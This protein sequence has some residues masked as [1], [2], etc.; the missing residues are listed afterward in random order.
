M[1]TDSKAHADAGK[2]RDTITR[3]DPELAGAVERPHVAGLAGTLLSLQRSHGNRFVH[4]L[5]SGTLIQ[6]KCSCGGT[7][8]QCREDH[9]EEEVIQRK[10]A[11]AS[12]PPVSQVPRFSLAPEEDASRASGVETARER[13]RVTN[14]NDESEM[15]ADRIAEQLMRVSDD[16]LRPA[17]SSPMFS[18]IHRAPRSTA[19]A[20][21]VKGGDIGLRLEGEIARA[22]S[23]G[24]PLGEATRS[25]FEARLGTDFRDVRIHSGAEAAAV[26]EKLAA[27]AFTMGH[28]IFFNRG[29]YQPES[30]EGMKLL[31]HELVHVVQQGDR[32]A[33]QR[34]LQRSKI[35]YR[36]LTWSDFKATPDMGSTWAAVT[37][38]GFPVPGWTPTRDAVDTKKE[39]TVDKAKSTEFTATVKVDPSVYDG[40]VALM[41]QEESWVKP[42]HK[43]DGKTW[44]NGQAT[45]CEKDFD[46]LAAQAKKD[47]K[48]EAD[49]CAQA[50]KHGNTSYTLTVGGTKI[51]ASD[52]SECA[53][54]LQPACE[55]AE[56]KAASAHQLP[57]SDG[58]NFASAKT[59]ADCK[60]D[61]VEK[62]KV[63]EAAESARILKH[64]QGHFD[65]SKVMADKARASLKAKAATFTA[66]ETRCGKVAALNAAIRSFNAFNASTV[67]GKLGSDWQDSKEKAESDYDDQTNHGMK[68]PE[69]AAWEAKITGGLNEYDPTKPPPTTTPATPGPA[70]QQTTPGSPATAPTQ[71]PPPKTP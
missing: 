5:A 21:T 19:A 29:R 15:E 54:K 45:D 55:A 63:H 70:T 59:K 26:S 8:E 28:D 31:G 67:L 68:K 7:C 25:F 14:A 22:A 23:Q 11:G 4:D 60:K 46:K 13:L 40:V 61:F 52:A 2:Q 37:A 35:S 38:S 53:S 41:T 42:R 17:E 47:C 1:A 58:V 20:T 10:R 33:A 9:D 71:N 6:R 30:S 3:L 56:I 48:Q 64:E 65:I 34:L 51:T 36:A 27:D 57:D 18:V 32:T 66:T 69:Q 49:N 16:E 12:N 43:D 39:C 50:F 44:C 62:C 24:E